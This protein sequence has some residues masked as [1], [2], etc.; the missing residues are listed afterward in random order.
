MVTSPLASYLNL[1]FAKLD[2]V[3]KC[4]GYEIIVSSLI[5]KGE[6]VKKTLLVVGIAG[7]SVGPSASASGLQ[8]DIQANLVATGH[9]KVTQAYESQKMSLTGLLRKADVLEAGDEGGFFDGIHPE[10]DLSLHPGGWTEMS[11]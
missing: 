8:N 10:I 2:V 4:P 6:I 11:K 3:S 1:S 5:E 9:E 7:A